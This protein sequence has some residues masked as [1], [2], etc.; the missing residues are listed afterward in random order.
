MSELEDK[1]I[2]LQLRTTKFQ[3]YEK[4]RF[5]LKSRKCKF[6]FLKNIKPIAIFLTII[7][8]NYF[9]NLKKKNGSQKKYKLIQ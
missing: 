3:F 9:P 7:K 5:Y 6:D 8:L 4:Y 2:E 1:T